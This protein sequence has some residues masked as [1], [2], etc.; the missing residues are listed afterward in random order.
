MNLAPFNGKAYPAIST[1]G[2]HNYEDHY[3][4]LIYYWN[5]LDD[6]FIY[7]VDD[8]NWDQ[9]RNGTKDAIQH[10]DLEILWKKE[11]ILT[12]NNE[13]TPPSNFFNSGFKNSYFSFAHLSIIL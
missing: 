3:K 13:H 11:I 12:G 2:G 6:L 9:V 1:L 7:I 10:Q 5:C 4:A 8:W